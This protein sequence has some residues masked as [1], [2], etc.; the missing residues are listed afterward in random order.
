MIITKEKFYLPRM[1]LTIKAF[2]KRLF[3]FNKVEEGD[4]DRI[5]FPAPIS[6][7]D[8]EQKCKDCLICMNICP[9]QCITLDTSIK[10]FSIDLVKCTWCL[11]CEES[12]PATILKW[13]KKKITLAQKR[14]DLV[15]SLL[16][17]S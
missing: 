7:E 13:E 6:S 10:E 12:C 9:E 8:I 5:L 1:V 2:I 17:N 4:S 15:V 14:D 11:K 16:N 3:N